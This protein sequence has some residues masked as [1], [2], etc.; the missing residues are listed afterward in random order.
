VVWEPLDLVRMEEPI[1][2]DAWARPDTMP[3]SSRYLSNRNMSN[4]RCAGPNESN[5]NMVKEGMVWAVV[6][7]LLGKECTMMFHSRPFQLAILGAVVEVEAVAEVP[8]RHKL[9]RV[10]R[11]LT[12]Q[13][14]LRMLASLVQT[15]VV[16][17]EAEIEVSI[18]TLVNLTLGTGRSSLESVS[19]G[20]NLSGMLF[21]E[22]SSYLLG[23][24]W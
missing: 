12:H 4:S 5:L 14:A 1:L 17:V 9:L 15:I 11:L 3:T 20:A 23:S 2:E 21:D 22:P 18:H 8:N 10:L 7:Q 13:L 16:V 24:S 19:D 6:D